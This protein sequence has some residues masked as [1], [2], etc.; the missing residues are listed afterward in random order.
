MRQQLQKYELGEI[1]YI[2]NVLAGEERSRVHTRREKTEQ[3]ILVD[4]E[5]SSESERD[6]QTTERFQLGQ[7][8]E[9]I[10][11]EARSSEAGINVTASYGAVSV[12]AHAQTQSS[13]SAEQ[14][15]K[16][17]RNYMKKS[18]SRAVE[19]IQKRTRTEK[20]TRF[21]SETLERNTH[22]FSAVGTD[23]RVGIYRYVEK[24]YFCQTL[25]YGAR[26]MIEFWVPEPAVYYLHAQ[27]TNKKTV[28]Q[29]IAPEEPNITPADIT[30]AS[31]QALAAR[32]NADVTEPPAAFE[33]GG[34][35]HINKGS[36][37]RSSEK[38]TIPDGYEI[39]YATANYVM[40]TPR[41]QTP[42]PSLT[43]FVGHHMWDTDNLWSTQFVV[44]HLRGE[45]TVR[46]LPYQTVT[47]WLIGMSFTLARTAELYEK[48][49]LATF[50]AIMLA[51]RLQ[52]DEYDRKLSALDQS[53]RP[54]S[55]RS[56]AEYRSIENRELQRGA[57]ELLTNQHFDAFK[58]IDIVNKVPTINNASAQIEGDIVRFF[59]HSFEWENMVYVFYPY[60]WGRKETW[61]DKIAKYDAD[62][63]HARFL[64]A[65]YARIVAPVRK[66][67][68]KHVS[69]YLATG[70]RWPD[71]EVP[72]IGSPEY[73]SI[74]DE[75]KRNDGALSENPNDDGI[76]EGAPWRVVLPTPLVCLESNSVHLPNW[77]IKPPGKPTPYI[78]SEDLCDGVPYNVAQWPNLDTVRLELKALGF[79]VVETGTAEDFFRG[80]AGQRMVKAFQ[81][82]V[83]DLGIS[84]GLGGSLK[85]DG[86]V[87]PCTL[88]ALSVCAEKRL[89]GEWP[90]PSIA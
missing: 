90:G 68:E 52:K 13:S 31:Y 49:Q 16:N 37:D 71:G 17:A 47:D 86:V 18:V 88:R 38:Y 35:L 10:Q 40:V 80:S 21:T 12:S 11:K 36:Q 9:T 81:R 44:P 45:V 61:P 73:V 69:A 24:H 76:A 1:A 34:G 2:E 8:L 43:W 4:I 32:Y 26:M 3:Q 62:P 30:D 72:V 28:G 25:N 77:E 48:W 83:N 41:G 22:S 79:G 70:V 27:V 51:Y 67:Y 53:S 60:F 58:S 54:L 64:E 42:K 65:G 78:P 57:L 84:A 74:I 39:N 63:V 33:Y 85:V 50:N 5:E 23:S 87:G 89:R 82:R 7:E 19:R 15:L 59:E 75:I 46:V 14:A 55:I 56:D 29:L 20:L 6:L 66:G